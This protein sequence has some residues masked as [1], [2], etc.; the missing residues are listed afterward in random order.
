M[1]GIIGRFFESFAIVVTAGVLVSLIISLTLT[2]ML[3]SKFLAMKEK[4]VYW[5]RGLNR[6]FEKLDTNYKEILAWTLSN[7]FKVLI[8]SFLIVLV[9]SILFS[10]VEKTLVPEQD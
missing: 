3:C 10:K 6:F 8:S 7:R 2:P 4:E 5:L 9:S 1:D